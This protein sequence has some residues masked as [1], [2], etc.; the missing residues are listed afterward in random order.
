M[1][2]NQSRGQNRSRGQKSVTWPKRSVA[3]FNFL[4]FQIFNF[5]L[6]LSRVVT[7]ILQ[8]Q[9]NN[10]SAT[11]ELYRDAR[12]VNERWRVTKNGQTV[13]YLIKAFCLI[14]VSN[15]VYKLTCPIIIIFLNTCLLSTGLIIYLSKILGENQNIEEQKVV[16][17]DKCMGVS[18]LLGGHL[19]GYLSPKYVPS[20]YS[21]NRTWA[22][23]DPSLENPFDS[24]SARE[25]ADALVRLALK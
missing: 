10:V 8:L 20:W 4:L 2:K 11:A 24:S 17:C 7:T 13:N 15:K 18:Q 5:L 12:S 25:K 9:Y 14:S 1:I 19:P 23:L 3:W 22:S 6:L 16:K 21:G